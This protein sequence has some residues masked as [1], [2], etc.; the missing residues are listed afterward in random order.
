MVSTVQV[1]SFLETRYFKLKT[2]FFVLGSAVVVPNI[3]VSSSCNVIVPVRCT[4]VALVKHV[5][6]DF[7]AVT[8][9]TFGF[10]CS[11]T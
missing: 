11:S 8:I 4:R 9:L 1:D 5:G 2:C 3:C 7:D 10:H 6:V